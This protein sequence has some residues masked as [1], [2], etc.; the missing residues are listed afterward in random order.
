MTEEEEQEEERLRDHGQIHHGCKNHT[1]KI[2]HINFKMRDKKRRIY[3]I[4]Q[5]EKAML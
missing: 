3:Y 5:G 4:I 2:S 1:E